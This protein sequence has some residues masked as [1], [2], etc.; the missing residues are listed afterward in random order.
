VVLSTIDFL[1][2]FAGIEIQVSTV[3]AILCCA[4][5]IKCIILGMVA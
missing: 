5:V 2:T 4:Y 1:R 3:N